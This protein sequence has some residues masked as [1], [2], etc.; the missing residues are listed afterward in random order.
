MADEKISQLA[1][2]TSPQGTDEFPIARGAS[3]FSLT[4]SELTTATG[5]LYQPVDSD[6]TAIAA[7]STTSYG[8]ALLTLAN[9]AAADWIA[10]ALVDA[11]GDLLVATADNTPARLGVGSDGQVLTADSTQTAGVKWA[12]ASGGGITYEDSNLVIAMEVYA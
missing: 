10:N 3:N 4:W 2:G 11:K 6:L 5:A 12:T 8:R 7:L 9:A 1:D